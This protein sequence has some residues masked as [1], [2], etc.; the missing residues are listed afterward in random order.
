VSSLEVEHEPSFQ[1]AKKKIPNRYID[2][3]SSRKSTQSILNPTNLSPVNH[4]WA[5]VNRLSNLIYN[6]KKF[7]ELLDQIVKDG[8]L[9]TL[10]YRTFNNPM[11]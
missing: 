7:E 10:L 4:A 11:P 2:S 1:S 9:N 3:K 8:I 6:I 5:N